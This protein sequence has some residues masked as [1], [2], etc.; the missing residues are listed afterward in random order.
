MKKIILMFAFLA[1]CYSASAEGYQVNAQSQRNIAMGHTGTG[2]L[3]GASSVHFNPGALSLMSSNFEFSLGGTMVLSQVSYSKQNSLYQAQT[4]NPAGTPLYLYAAGK[5]NDNL[6]ASLGVTTPYGNSL[7]WKSDWD[8]RFLIQDISLS[9]IVVQ[10]TLS[11]KINDKLGF[12]LGAM[13]A[14]GSVDLN[15]ALPLTSADGEGSTNL[16][17]STTSVGFNAGVFY[18]ATD[19]LSLGLN[20]RSKVNMKMDGGDAFFTVPSDLEESFPTENKFGAELPLPA[21]L[22]F[23]AGFKVSEKLTL[24][25]D[26]QYVFW[27]AYE[28]LDFDFEENTS[29]LADSYN[30]RDYNNTLIYRIGAEYKLSNKFVVRAG[31][32]YDETPI[33]DDRLNP[34]T[35][36]MNKIG[37][38]TGASYQVTNRLAID[39]SL[40]YIKGIER[41]A[42]YEPANFYG[43]YNSQAYLPGI[44]VTYTF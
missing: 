17:G 25:L 38:S 33:S 27:S 10:P 29:S 7:A 36:G 2:L 28:S 24:A 43:T 35:P 18:Q 23:G 8:G 13:I 5:I 9:A 39:A 31:A 30:P 6:I 16:Q 3:L 15:K 12:G 37:L 40:L 22:T 21:N 20:Y 42:G 1:I 34:E 32:Y 14:F 4:D 41:E 19:A 44:G 26:L 11:Y